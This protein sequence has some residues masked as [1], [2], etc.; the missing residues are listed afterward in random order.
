MST[1]KFNGFTAGTLLTASGKKG[2]G[3]Y[4]QD[5]TVNKQTTWSAFIPKLKIFEIMLLKNT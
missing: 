4:Q 3:G 5:V 2:G 1:S